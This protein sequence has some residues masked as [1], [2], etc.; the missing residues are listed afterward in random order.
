MKCKVCN[1]ELNE[2]QAFCPYCGTKVVAPVEQSAPAEVIT[3]NG[4][5][6]KSETKGA[7]KC[8]L[9]GFIVGIASLVCCCIGFPAGIAGIILSAKGLKSNRKGFAIPGLILSILAVIYG[10]SFW[11]GFAQG[12]V[13]G[14]AGGDF[15]MDYEFM[16]MIINNLPF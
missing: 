14:L 15:D 7:D 10:I 2:G 5:A 4:E 3:I 12:I 9:I 16:S 11:I 6:P 13:Q 8:A 1:S